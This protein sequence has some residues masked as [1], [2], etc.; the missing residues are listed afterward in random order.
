M[1]ILSL[2]TTTRSRLLSSTA[3]I[4]YYAAGG[5]NPE[6]VADFVRGEYSAAGNR[7]FASTIDHSASGLATMTGGYGPELISNGEFD[8]DTTGWTNGSSAVLSAVSGELEI[9]NSSGG[10]DGAVYALSGLIS[11]KQYVVT[12]QLRGVSGS[13]IELTVL[14]NLG[15]TFLLRTTPVTAASLTKVVGYWTAQGSQDKVYLRMP[16]NGTAYADNISVREAPKLQ[17]RPHNLLTYSEQFDNAAWIISPSGTGSVTKGTADAATAPDGTSTADRVIFDLAGGTTTGDIALLRQQ[18]ATTGGLT[19]SVYLRSSDGLSSYTMQIILPD[20]NGSNI[21]VTGSWQKFEVSGTSSGNVNYGIRLRGGQSPANSDYAD[22]L[23]W[24]AHLYR[25]DL[26]GMAPVPADFQT[27]GSE[28]YVRT[29]GRPIGPELVTNGTFDTDTTGWTTTAP[30]TATWNAGQ[31]DLDRNNGSAVQQLYQAQTFTLG[32]VYEVNITVSALSHN[33]GLYSTGGGVGIGSTITSTGDHTLYFVGKSG[34]NGIYIGAGGSTTAT[35]TIDNVSVQEIDVNPAT[36]RYL[37]RIGHHVYNGSQWVDEG[38]FHESEAR[39]NLIEYSE[40]FTDASWTKTNTATLAVDATGPDGE[41]SAV[42]L[43]DSGAG[44]TGDVHVSQVYSLSTSTTYTVSMFMKA[45]QLSVG[46]IRF[47]GFTTPADSRASFNLSDGTVTVSAGDQTT[48]EDFGNGW[49]R[50]AIT[51]TT[52]AADITGT[53]RYAAGDEFSTVDLDG[54]SSILIYGAQ[55]EAGS[56]PSSYIPTSGATATRAAETLTIP[57]ENLTWP[58]P[59]VIG[60]E[61]VTN[62]TFDTDTTGWSGLNSANVTFSSGRVEVD[63]AAVSGSG[64]SSDANVPVELGKVYLV[65]ADIEIGTY[66]GSS[67]ILNLIGASSPAQ[68]VASSGVTTVSYV[69]YGSATTNTSVRVLR[70]S[71]DTGT[72]FIDNVSV[73]EIK[74]LAVS[75]QM[76]GRVTYADTNDGGEVI[77][78]DW[79][80]DSSNRIRAGID[81]NSTNVGQVLWLQ[82]ASGTTDAIRSAFDTFTPGVNVPFNIASRHGSTFINGAVDGVALTEDTTPVALPDLSTTDLELGYDFMGTI[83]KFR[84]WADDIGDTGLEEATEPSLEPSLSLT[85]DGSS[86]SFTVFD[87]SE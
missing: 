77:F 8:S 83:K 4:R 75:I 14:N 61:L 73:R 80:F 28:T 62:G 59:V 52:D 56:T 7:T 71:A 48:I 44:G 9:V 40:D 66:T 60:E 78:S 85:F 64:I 25:S 19:Y 79:R 51:F 22:V 33:V 57:Y 82:A 54:T 41:T 12:A 35:A 39:T 50:C 2:L 49:Y 30:A 68:A 67:V 11:G 55:L 16:S 10:A 27:A 43:V 69:F 31:V 58:E 32:S 42:T 3:F 53:I 63:I 1:P 34:D 84:M 6:F 21:T 26:G 23:I 87:W 74:P 18:N 65:S 47:A 70:G 15:T 76:D 46:S 5:F 20:G 36:A 29:A 81:T 38:I 72:I 13:D 37:P 24:G 86:T 17:W 45:D